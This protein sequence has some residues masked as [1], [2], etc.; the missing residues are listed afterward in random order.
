M[1]DMSMPSSPRALSAKDLPETARLCQSIASQTPAPDMTQGGQTPSAVYVYL[2]PEGARV[3][4][5]ARYQFG[6]EKRFCPFTLWET[7]PGVFQWAMKGLPE[8]RHLY[9]LPELRAHLGKVV[10]LSEG[11]KCAD[12]AAAAFPGYVSTTWMGGSNAVDKTDFTPLQGYDVIILQD[13][14]IAGEKATEAL[15][16]TLQGVGVNRLR[17][18]NTA[19]LAALMT[20]KPGEGFDIADAIDAGLVE[21]QFSGFLEQ[22]DMITEASLFDSI[23]EE[24][25]WK[26]FRFKL[27]LPPVFRLTE[28]GIIK[29]EVDRRSGE[30]SDV[31]AGSPMAVLGK[32]R[33]AGARAGWGYQVAVRNPVGEWTCKTIPGRLLAGDGREMREILADEGFV[34][35]QQL[36]GR[37]ALAE[38]VAY[39][40]DCQIIQVA[41][42]PGWHGESFTL[43]DGVLS[44]ASC[45]VPVAMDMGDRPHFLAVAGTSEG[46]QELA[47]LTAQSSRATFAICVALAAPLLRLLGME[48]GGFHF[49]GPSSRGKTAMLIIAGSV[50]GGGGK[51]GFVRSWRTTDN[52]AE[53]LIAD[54]NDLL[55]PLDEMTVVSPDDVFTVLYMLANGHSKSRA[56]VNGRLA[57]ALQWLALILSSGE[58]RISRHLEQ[59]RGRIH[60]T[61]GLAVRMVD[62]PIEIAPEISFEGHAP[63][64]SE[65]HFV[66]YLTAAAKKNYGHAGRAFIREILRDRDAVKDEANK[67]IARLRNQF[68]E[69]DDDPQVERV[70][71]RFGVVAAAGC[72][73]ADRG[74]LPMSPDQVTQAIVTVFRSWKEDRGGGESEERRNALRHL[75]HFFEAHGSSR[76]EELVRAKD[77]NDP[78]RRSDRS[79]RDRC[80]YRVEQEDGAWL[81]YVLPVAW[82]REVCG[83]HAP[84][85]VAK[86]AL[87]SGALEPGEG[88][89][90]QKNVR[91]PDYPGTTRVYAVRPDMLP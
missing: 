52:G 88:R 20:H 4:F 33:M 63:F 38:Y 42:R 87:E 64:E 39:A 82:E 48:G 7:E 51:D 49:H 50:W 22:P 12:A 44:P 16:A 37:R 26:R 79:V 23:I 14:D 57:A 77:P 3:C 24:E 21:Q 73:A 78:E 67:H 90:R 11:E 71:K 59:G 27:D 75:K 56:A 25:L 8:K 53:A 29:T 69:P 10:L 62:I 45:E 36:A 31:F 9:R 58:H 30:I 70:A 54:H 65:G 86:I 43:P 89:H 47:S 41:D 81:Y 76:F 91:L 61:G 17:C 68:L 72:I 66:D 2:D 40:Q 18:F 6:D 85:L 5:V 13:D 1:T 80:G 46:W 84:D 35:P 19:R 15:I 32:T 28:H 55:L 60:M 34:V 74:I 83:P